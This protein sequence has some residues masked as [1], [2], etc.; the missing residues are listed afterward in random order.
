MKH[1]MKKLIAVGYGNWKKYKSPVEGARDIP[2][3][4]FEVPDM[5]LQVSYPHGELA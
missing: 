5:S 3:I 1:S 4:V 2:G